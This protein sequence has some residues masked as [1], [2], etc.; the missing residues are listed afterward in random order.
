[1]KF[2]VLH[3]IHSEGYRTYGVGTVVD[4]KSDLSKFNRPGSV[5]FQQVPDDTPTQE[6]A[7]QL[8]AEAGA[9][10]NTLP[11]PLKDM[12]VNELKRLAEDEEAD[13]E[14]AKTKEQII[15]AIELNREEG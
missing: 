12:T 10:D 6:Q 13:L 3:G 15:A 11:T 5:R 14:G 1:M 4:S 8:A 7:A 9:K 2:K